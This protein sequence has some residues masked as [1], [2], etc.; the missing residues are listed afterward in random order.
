MARIRSIKP[1]FFTDD[2]IA[3]LEPIER[4]FFIGLFTQADR[5]GRLE[6]RP[7]RLKAQ[8]LPFDDTDADKILTR[9]NAHSE[10]FIIR[11]EVEGKR[12]IQI[13]TFELHQKPHHQEPD[14]VIPTID[15]LE[16]SVIK[17][18]SVGDS[19]TQSVYKGGFSR[20]LS[21]KQPLVQPSKKVAPKESLE[22]FNTWWKAYPKKVGRG[23]VLKIW[24]KQVR[25]KVELS[26]MLSILEKQKASDQWQKEGGQ[27]IPNPATYLNQGRWDDEV[28]T[29]KT[30]EP[31]SPFQK[32]I[33]ARKAKEANHGS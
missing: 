1:G 20:S 13:R 26:K 33:D 14:S 3:E 27:F 5:N 22:D 2:F 18:K 19:P 23:A 21:C 12:Y 6:D 7:R 11:Y 4:L 29:S 15:K 28:T 17:P 25:G 24:D 8:I 10:R 32:A 31:I 9:L 16:T 30:T